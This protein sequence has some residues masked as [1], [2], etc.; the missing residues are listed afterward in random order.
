MNAK[1]MYSRA[2]TAAVGPDD[3]KLLFMRDTISGYQRFGF[4]VL[5][6]SSMGFQKLLVKN[7][8]D[9]G[10]TGGI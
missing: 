9:A 8:A 4:D 7:A 10:Q 1:M 3:F 5:Y 2:I 6:G